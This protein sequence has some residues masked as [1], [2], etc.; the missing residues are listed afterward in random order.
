MS[1]ERKFKTEGG[2][3]ISC[4][5]PCEQ[6]F[7]VPVE[8][9]KSIKDFKNI[10]TKRCAAAGAYLRGQHFGSDELSHLNNI[11]GCRVCTIYTKVDNASGQA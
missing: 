8:G 11:K 9:S 4:N 7:A 2:D 3:L 10:P 5:Q 6:K 1:G